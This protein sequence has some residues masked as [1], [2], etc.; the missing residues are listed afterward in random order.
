MI[1]ERS[2]KAYQWIAD[3]DFQK[4]YDIPAT[5]SE[6]HFDGAVKDVDDTIKALCEAVKD[7]ERFTAV[8][9]PESDGY[10]P[11]HTLIVSDEHVIQLFA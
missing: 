2:A 7:G 5:A 8:F 6:A 4:V 11:S 9:C 1:T 3:N 10:P